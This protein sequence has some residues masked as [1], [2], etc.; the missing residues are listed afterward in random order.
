[1]EKENKS[2]K[3][4][5]D[6]IRETY[7]FFCEKL[8]TP[9]PERKLSVMNSA[10]QMKEFVVR[11]LITGSR[12]SQNQKTYLIGLATDPTGN[13]HIAFWGSEKKPPPEPVP[14]LR[15]VSPMIQ[16]SAVAASITN[17]EHHKRM[18]KKWRI[19]V[20]DFELEMDPGWASAGITRA[21][22]E[23]I[24]GLEKNQEY[25]RCEYF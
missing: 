24:A 25:Q 10:R 22:Q 21:I 4:Y 19:A 14:E 12:S 16:V 18:K 23:H 9:E 15:P 8:G 7:E 5:A 11:D 20:T 6:A 3:T 2:L 13:V 1:M 17:S